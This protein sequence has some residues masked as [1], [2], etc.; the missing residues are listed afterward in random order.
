MTDLSQRWHS[1]VLAAVPLVF[2]TTAALAQ[3][4]SGN[5]FDNLFSRGERQEQ[6]RQAAPSSERLR[7]VS[8]GLDGWKTSCASS[9]ARSSNC[10]SA[11]S[12]SSCAQALA[13]GQR[14]PVPATRRKR[15]GA[16]VRR[17]AFGRRACGCCPHASQSAAGAAAC[18]IAADAGPAFGCVRS[19]S[20]AQRAR[21]AAR[22]GRWRSACCVAPNRKPR[23]AHPAAAQPVRRLI[24]RA[25]R[26]RRRSGRPP[27]RAAARGRQSGRDA[28]AVTVARR[29]STISLTVMC[30]GRIMRSP[31]NPSAIF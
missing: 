21:R 5:V 25:S 3:E 6:S 2:L 29:T 28:A 16:C 27:Q 15:R 18:H 20:I 17:S 31:N 24:S 23:S 22:A 9:P 26:R 13:R 4:R 10:S 12:S 14:I 11:I 19:Q 1:A 8:R 30:C 7:D